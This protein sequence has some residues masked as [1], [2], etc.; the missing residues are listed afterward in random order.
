MVTI[1][2]F[3]KKTNPKTNESYSVLVVQSDPEVLVSKTGRA[4]I[5]TRKATVASSLDDIQANALI[6]K[7]LPGTIEKVACTPFEVKLPNGKK[8]KISTSFQY[9]PEPVATE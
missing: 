8:A 2:K 9:S 1:V 3:E 5:T 6:G 7:T 4:Y